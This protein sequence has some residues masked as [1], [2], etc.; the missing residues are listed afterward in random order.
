M[1]RGKND[2][3]PVTKGSGNVFADLGFSGPE[4]EVTKAQLA[5]HIRHVLRQRRLTQVNAAKLMGVDQPKVSALLNG[6]LA[7]FSS[8]RLMRLLTALG[9]DVEITVRPTPKSRKRGH[10]RVEYA[11]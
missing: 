11:A 1:A 7:N 6:R 5:D 4:E 2:R 3:I 9:R 8:E 10:I